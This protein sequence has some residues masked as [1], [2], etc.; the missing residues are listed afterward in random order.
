MAEKKVQPKAAETEAAS[1]TTAAGVQK[2]SMKQSPAQ[3]SRKQSRK[4]GR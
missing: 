3:Q 2:K 4:Q 1:K